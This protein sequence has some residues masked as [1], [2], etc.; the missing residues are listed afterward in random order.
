MSLEGS[1]K[2]LCLKNFGQG[3]PW[4]SWE[5]INESLLPRGI[6]LPDGNEYER[7]ISLKAQLSQ[8]YANAD[9]ARKV[10]LT[11]YYICTWGRVCA[12]KPETIEYYALSSTDLLKNLG[13]SG[14]ASWSKALC[15]RDPQRYV[16]F[17]ARISVSLHC[18]S[19]I[20]GEDIGCWMPTLLS[21]NP[22]ITEANKWLRSIG[23][24]KRKSRKINTDFYQ[25]YLDICLNIAEDLHC[26]PGA[27]EMLLFSSVFDLYALARETHE[28]SGDCRPVEEGRYVFEL[29]EPSE[30]RIVHADG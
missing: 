28:A 13:S 15:I 12:N 30:R 18:L 27:V 5:P 19:I 23:S 8:E 29:P 10:L 25:H 16:I 2:S 11:D 6:E 20:S 17:D 3:N 24:V 9:R 21:R 1:V 7:N 14:V 22:T 26:P 4:Y